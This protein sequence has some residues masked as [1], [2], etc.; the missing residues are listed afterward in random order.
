MLTLLAGSANTSLLAQPGTVAFLVIFGMGV[1]CFFL[2]RSMSRHLRKVNKM[3]RDEAEA[4]EREGAE[5]AQ[6]QAAHSAGNG[7]SS[8]P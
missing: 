4:A 7:A 8:K 3:A 2:F 1:L 5:G 6:D